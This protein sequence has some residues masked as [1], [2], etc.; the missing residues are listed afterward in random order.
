MKLCA[1][2]EIDGYLAFHSLSIIWYIL[3]KMSDEKR[4]EYLRELCNILRVAGAP[5][6]DI[7]KAIEQSDFGF[8]GLFARQMCNQCGGRLHNN[9]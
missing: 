3:R 5:H 6:D 1:N 4:R 2:D 9:L 7:V 8:R